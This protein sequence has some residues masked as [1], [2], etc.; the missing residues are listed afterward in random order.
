MGHPEV[1]TSD[2]KDLDQYFGIAKVRILPPRGLY[3]PVLSYRS[4]GKLN[5]PLCRSCAE[6]ESQAPCDCSD[7]DRT[8][9]GTWCTPE[10]RTAIR[11]GYR[12]LKIYEV[13]HWEKTTRYDPENKEGGLLPVTTTHSSTINRKPVDLR[14]D[15][16]SW[17]H[18]K[19]HRSVLRKGSVATGRKKYRKEPWIKGSSQALPQ[20]LLGKVWTTTEPQTVIVLSRDGSRCFFTEYSL[21]PPKKSRMFTSWQR[22]DPGRMILLKRLATGN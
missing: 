7:E 2:F 1:T 10:L 11:L 8:M 19:V 3:H 4:N 9:T 15:P 12:V 20:Q 21:T 16:D 6:N 14:V 5:F 22:H 13:Y 17:R 18:P